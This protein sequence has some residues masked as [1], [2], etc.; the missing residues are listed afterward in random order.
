MK[1]NII[2]TL[3]LG[4]TC[5]TIVACTSI[6]PNEEISAT[7]SRLSAAYS[8]KNTAD[9]GRADLTSADA[10]LRAAQTA[11]DGGDT[12]ESDHYLTMSKTYLDL[13][14]T[15]GAQAGIEQE[16]DNLK[17][18]QQM[19]SARQ[20]SQM[21]AM[22]NQERLA[23]KDDQLAAPKPRCGSKVIRITLAQKNTTVSFHRPALTLS[24]IC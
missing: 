17:A 1:T 4:T 13:A 3:I 22:R 8:D 23:D 19:D 11:W 6:Q 18:Q 15:R 5:L 10:A 16:I 24:R 14:D 21:D 20:Q 9:R 7:Q 2:K 12:E